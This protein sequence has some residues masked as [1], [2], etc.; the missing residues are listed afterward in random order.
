MSRPVL[1]AA[2]LLALSACHSGGSPAPA[3]PTRTFYLGLQPWPYDVTQAA[4]DQTW[5]YLYTN[6]DIISEHFEEG[7]PW[8]EAYDGTAFAAG[9]VAEIQDHL[10]RTKANQRAFLELNAID[11]SRKTMAPYRNDQINQPLPA[12]WSTYMLND[13]HVKTAYLNYC[14]RMIQYF[15][16]VA[17]NIG[18]EANE[19]MRNT[20]ALWSQYVD[21]LS[22]TYA[23]LK[24]QYPKLPVIVSVSVVNYF[25]WLS[26]A[27]N[28]TFQG[29]Q[30][31][32]TDMLPYTDYLGLSFYPFMGTYLAEWDQLIADHPDF[33]DQIFT[34]ANKPM[35][36]TESGFPAVVW[37]GGGNTFNGSP[38][39]QQDVIKR[40]FAAADKYKAKFV[41]WFL[42]RDYYQMWQYYEGI[43]PTLASQLITWRDDGLYDPNGNARPSQATWA[44][45][46]AGQYVGSP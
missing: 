19:L 29:Q 26:G 41:V 43:D 14:S 44:S 31:A 9:Y 24:A 5:Q 36:F 20:P 45:R 3:P 13:A 30:T 34:L 4:V 2:A 11:S 18:I 21:L 8:Q 42:A 22:S 15:N 27:D 12:P 16:P 10:N 17:V 1:I 46:F 6:T 39:R 23:G 7:V 40:M 25:Q 38:A 28:T 37:S 35:A 32:L 33:F